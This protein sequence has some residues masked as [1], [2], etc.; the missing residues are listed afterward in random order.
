LVNVNLKSAREIGLMRVSG[1]IVA[2]ALALLRDMAEPGMT[3]GE[4]DRAV[5][6]LFAER[7]ATPLFKGV[8]GNPPYPACVC[9][10]VNEEVVHGI[11]GDRKLVEGDIVSVDTGCR[12]N[13]YC[14]DAATTLP[15]GT[16]EPALVELLDTTQRTLG[17]AIEELPRQKRWFDVAGRMEEYV[18]S[19]GFTVVEEFVGHGIGSEMHE[20][21]QVPNFVQKNAPNRANFKLE[22]G[23]VLA[24]EPMVNV[25]TKYVKRLGDGW[26]QVTRDGKASAH[27]EHT[28]ALVEGGV[29]VLTRSA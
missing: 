4:M 3:T 28:V 16:I 15:I 11:P 5:E 26:T 18:K 7:G 9:I 6:S 29:E 8:P 19:R 17:L 27:F 24:I 22:P 20:P 14:A 10:S 1:K 2:E 23:L 12:L 25:G 21:P 13:G